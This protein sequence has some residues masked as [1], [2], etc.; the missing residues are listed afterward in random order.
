MVDSEIK[1]STDPFFRIHWKTTKSSTI[2]E[3][4][5]LDGAYKGNAALGAISETEESL[6]DL[7][8][9]TPSSFYI[10][11][12]DYQP[13]GDNPGSGARFIVQPEGDKAKAPK[14]IIYSGVSVNGGET[15][16]TDGRAFISGANKY[17]GV[18]I[19][20]RYDGSYKTICGLRWDGRVYCRGL[21]VQFSDQC[22]KYGEDNSDADNYTSRNLFAVGV[23][24]VTGAAHGTVS[25]N[26]LRLT[27][28]QYQTASIPMGNDT[29]IR[30]NGATHSGARLNTDDALM[31]I[32]CD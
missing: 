8:K 4:D 13:G 24:A 31:F 9:I 14:L 29:K 7:I 20:V 23:N 18:G 12:A 17:T 26:T 2:E 6:M 27:L 1:S 25:G 32:N 28:K 19:Q 22:V 3:G 30:R 11:S 16:A 10:T 15:G 21:L 5:G